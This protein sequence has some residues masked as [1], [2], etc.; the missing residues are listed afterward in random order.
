LVLDSLY[1]LRRYYYHWRELTFKFELGSRVDVDKE[2]RI[3]LYRQVR[4]FP[5]YT[6]HHR[7]YTKEFSELYRKSSV[8]LMELYQEEGDL[9]SLLNFDITPSKW[10]TLAS[11]L[12]IAIENTG[13]TWDKGEIPWHEDALRFYKKN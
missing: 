8:S 2:T 12:K 6:V 7:F 11:F 9:E 3:M 10:S 1:S 13:G 5:W 4:V